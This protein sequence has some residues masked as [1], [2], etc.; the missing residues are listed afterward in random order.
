VRVFVLSNYF[1]PRELGGYELT[2]AAFDRHLVA[3]GH[4]VRVLT[5]DHP[6]TRPERAENAAIDARPLLR[7]RDDQAG[8]GGLGGVRDDR[9]DLALLREQ[10]DDFAPDVVTVWG[11]SGIS[12]ALLPALRGGPP[13]SARISD[14]WLE[15]RLEYRPASTRARFSEALRRRLG[16]PTHE[17]VGHVDRWVFNSGYMRDRAIAL[18]I[19]RGR[20]AVVPSGIDVAAGERAA[21]PWLG[22]LLYLG[23]LEEQKGVDTAIRAAAATNS[24]LRIVGDGEPRALAELD[25][26]IGPGDRIVRAPAVDRDGVPKEL[27]A[28]DA[29]LF[30]SRW[31]EPW[32]KTP[33][34]AM[35][36]GVP[37]IASGTGGSA[38]Y[39]RDGENALVVPADDDAGW[40]AAVARLAQDDALRAR[41]VAA[42]RE[43]AAGYS[44]AATSEK[45]ERELVAAVAA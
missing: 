20:T 27:A 14:A 24:A 10:L 11:M 38:E 41:L 39:L 45:L 17:P 26:L 21:G 44:E 37:V 43:T 1:P 22:R 36:A 30:P 5:S 8:P 7:R 34:E 25:A 29:L 6:V 19:P 32:G 40:A 31:A 4:A 12:R 3:G 28:A 35:A 23:R 13:V 18:G 16:V 15:R 9:R 2:C 42:G 33:L